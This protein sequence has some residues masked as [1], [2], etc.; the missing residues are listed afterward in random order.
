[1]INWV[2]YGNLQMNENLVPACTVVNGSSRKCSSSSD[3]L[4]DTSDETVNDINVTSMNIS[5][6][7]VKDKQQPLTAEEQADKI[8]RDV[9]MARARMFEV[10]GKI[11]TTENLNTSQIDEDYQMIDSHVD[12]VLKRKIQAMEYVELGKLIPKNRFLHNDDSQHQR[13]EIVNKNGMSFLA[14]ASDNSIVINSYGKWE[15]AFR[16]FSNIL[17][18]KFPG[19][20]TELLQYNHTIHSASTT[21]AGD[22]VYA[23]NKEFR[24][25]IARHPYR[26]WAIILQQAWTMLLKDRVVRGEYSSSQQRAGG[27]YGGSGKWKEICKRFNKGCCTYGLSCKYDHRCSV[28]K[29]GKFGHGAHICHLRIAQEQET[30]VNNNEPNSNNNNNNSGTKK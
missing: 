16:I 26:S 12:E 27:T 5:G 7:E 24:C 23:Y 10:P 1:M 17:T 6:Q 30:G 11:G 13:L 18:T 25:H 2:R 21:Y 8:V 14:P 19:K 4:M 20:S 3:E 22:N 28:P 29:C 15:Q 9:E